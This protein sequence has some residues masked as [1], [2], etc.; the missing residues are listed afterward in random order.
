MKRLLKPLLILAAIGVIGF[1]FVRSALSTRAEPYVVE[2]RHLQ[3]WIL[4]LQGDAGGN[5]PL[6]SLLL[7]RELAASLFRQLFT[8]AAESL[9]GPTVPYVPLVLGDEYRRT[10]SGKVTPRELEQAARDA[11]LD[12]GAFEPRCMVYR[13][14]SAPGVTRQLYFVLFDS[15]AFF[16]FRERVAG[17]ADDAGFDPAALSPVMFVAASDPDFNRWLPVRVEPDAD[18]LAPVSVE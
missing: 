18:C 9:S 13:R 11:G 6:L 10:L 5:T 4:S 8:R 3:Q 12:A 2:R 1:L 16:Q 15:P 14:E 7:P 17:L